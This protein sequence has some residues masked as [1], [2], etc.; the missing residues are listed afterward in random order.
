MPSLHSV[1]LLLLPLLLASRTLPAVGADLPLLRVSHYCVT[2][3]LR[4]GSSAPLAAVC[5]AGSGGPPLCVTPLH[6]GSS[7]RVSGCAEV[8]ADDAGTYSAATPPDDASATRGA[9]VARRILTD[10]VREKQQ[11]MGTH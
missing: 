5:I 10:H 8:H 4:P 2:A 1:L 3:P 6:G 9:V 7:V 11:Q